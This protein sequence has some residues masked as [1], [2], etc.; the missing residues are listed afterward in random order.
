MTVDQATPTI[1]TQATAN[2]TIGGQI[3]DT[4]TLAGRLGRDRHDH[5][6]RLCPR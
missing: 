5:L 2:A 1:S 6:Q 3:I 4:A